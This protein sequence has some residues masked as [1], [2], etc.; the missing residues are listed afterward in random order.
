[1]C[2]KSIHSH[3]TAANNTAKQNT[4]NDK[5]VHPLQATSVGPSL[6][7]WA[8]PLVLKCFKMLIQ[9]RECLKGQK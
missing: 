4:Q 1:M 7:K 3:V 8:C 9:E 6:P 2:D 5:A